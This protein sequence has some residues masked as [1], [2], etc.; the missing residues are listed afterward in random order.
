MGDEDYAPMGR[1]LYMKM[2]VTDITQMRDGY[3]VTASCAVS[4]GSIWWM[5]GEKPEYEIGQTFSISF[6]W[7]QE[8]K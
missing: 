8:L 3:G 5:E 2:T 6:K 1:P 7:D 4:G